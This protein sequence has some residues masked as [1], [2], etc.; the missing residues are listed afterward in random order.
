MCCAPR[1]CCACI[2]FCFYLP[3]KRDPAREG[4]SVERGAGRAREESSSS[5]SHLPMDQSVLH[6][7]AAQG[8]PG[9]P[10]AVSPMA[11]DRQTYRQNAKTLLHNR[12]RRSVLSF[13]LLSFPSSCHFTQSFLFMALQ[14]TLCLHLQS[15]RQNLQLSAKVAPLCSV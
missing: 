8:A 15:V 3:S 4:R 1:L 13:P 6:A 2:S 10:P 7:E 11:P 5:S 9:Q 14:L 12:P